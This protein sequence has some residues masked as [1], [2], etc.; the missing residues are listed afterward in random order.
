[1]KM[2]VTNNEK[3]CA[4]WYP[5]KYGVGLIKN[6]YGEEAEK[7]TEWEER[8]GPMYKCSNCRV[9]NF[10]DNYCPNCGAKMDFSILEI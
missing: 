8:Y 6:V 4:K 10:A 3:N 2:I 1:M 9:V 7:K 5:F